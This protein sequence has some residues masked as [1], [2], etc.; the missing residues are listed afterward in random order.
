MK[1]LFFNS[2]RTKLIV[3]FLVV[4]L[5]PLL[6]LA[7]INKQTTEK[8]LTDNARQALSA[9]ANETAYRIDGFIDG[10]L[11]AVRVEA[12]L[13]GLAAYLGIPPERRNG[14]PQ[15]MLATETLTRLSR[16]DTLNIISYALLNLK[17]RNVLD[18]NT[19]DVGRDESG[20]DYFQ[21]PL[22]TQLSFVSSIRQSPT[23]PN[24]VTLFFSSPVR[25]AKGNILGILRVTYNATSV[26]QLVSRK[27][28]RA[29][30]KSLAVLLDE[31]YIH[32]AHSTTPELLFKS[33]VP[34]SPNV[35]AQLQREGRLPK[36]IT[37]ELA[38]N[39]PDLKQA[40]DTKQPYLITRLTATGNNELSLLAIARLQY[41]PWSVL[42]A[43]PIAVALAPVEK[44]IQDALLLLAIIATIVTIIAL[45]IAQLLT[46]PVIYLTQAVAEFTAGHLDMR[47]KMRSRDE[48]GLLARSFNSMARQIQESFET[49]EDKVKERT[50][51]LANANQEI[52]TLN[53]KLKVDNLRLGAELNVARQIQQMIL[54]NPHELEI[55]GLDIAG[56]ME[57]A[58]EVGGDYYDVLQ[59]DGVVTLAIGDVTGH[60]LE[61]GILMLMAQTSVRTL[62]EIRGLDPVRFLDVLNRTLYKNVQRMN[63]EKSLTLAILN[64]SEGRISISGQHEETLVVR[65]NGDVE[66]IDTME[67][68]FPIA[69]DDDIADFISHVLI[70]LEPGDG[71]VLY[72]DGIP[73]AYNIRKKQYGLKQLCQVISQNWH[74]SAAGV[75]DAVIVDVRQ[76]IGKQK[77]FDDIT[78]LVFK[79]QAD[80][81]ENG[82]LVNN[83][84]SSK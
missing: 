39:L 37:E 67:L 30:A 83:I 47:V 72:T 42:F 28:E 58:D 41:Q 35:V 19:L 23:I 66:R 15:E 24:L 70:E 48:I 9:A 77:V 56:Y 81:T 78:L 7:F 75:K 6:L 27:T 65:K 5:I 21:E 4:A 1:R 74:K 20:Q 82:N 29:G 69:L 59:I 10:N 34:L 18:T 44:Q 33:I 49:L 73:E 51:E 76:H 32:L 45:A 84:I 11:N 71:V 64:Y 52:I 68:G 43:Q 50:S 36:N 16:K 54:P 60:G 53:E 8:A 79:R 61:S 31:N 12:I 17:G 3:S 62:Q 57:P 2:I 26:Q 63:S 40:L 55:D 25:D 22:K 38:I 46:K 80:V 13:P 14:S